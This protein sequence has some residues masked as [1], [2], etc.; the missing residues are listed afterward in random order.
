MEFKKGDTIELIDNYEI[1]AQI[2]AR[3]IVVEEGNGPY[4]EI[5]WIRNKKCMGQMDG[6]YGKET[7]KI[8]KR[9][10]KLTADDI[11]KEYLDKL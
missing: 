11:N 5:K 8:Y 6:G 1:G 4:V 10:E 3:A 2:G 7:F 9:A